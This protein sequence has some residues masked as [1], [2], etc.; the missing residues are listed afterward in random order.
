MEEEVFEI[1]IRKAK[2]SD[3]DKIKE[4]FMHYEAGRKDVASKI[5]NVYL[6]MC[7]NEIVGLR[8]INK[9]PKGTFEELI[10]SKNFQGM[11]VGKGM[12][13]KAAEDKKIKGDYS[14]F[15]FHKKFGVGKTE[16]AVFGRTL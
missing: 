3:V 8:I 12:V 5:A 16:F 2:K 15:S 6:A 1:K 4:I 9:V 7:N 11:K 14:G 13:M 10:V